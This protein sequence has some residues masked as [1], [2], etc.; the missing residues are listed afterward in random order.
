M[1]T[2][3]LE[4]VSLH[5]LHCLFY[6]VRVHISFILSI[7][8]SFIYIV[9]AAPIMNMHYFSYMLTVRKKIFTKPC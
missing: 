8:V 6:C 1:A 3:D 9:T 4:L 5:L 7:S 2:K